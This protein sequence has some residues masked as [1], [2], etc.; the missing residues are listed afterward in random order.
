MSNSDDESED[1]SSSSQ[2]APFIFKPHCLKVHWK[3]GITLIIKK[4]LQ[5]G[6]T[7]Q[8]KGRSIQL[9]FISQKTHAFRLERLNINDPLFVLEFTNTHT[10]SKVSRNTTKISFT[11][12][13]HI[14]WCIKTI[15]Q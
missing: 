6:M 14:I 9:Y 15:S 7:I 11:R 4:S 3:T 12:N 1:E 2:S 8:Y 13:G 10:I 5:F